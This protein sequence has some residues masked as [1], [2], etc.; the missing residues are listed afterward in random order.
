VCLCRQLACAANNVM[1]AV[2]C[3]SVVAGWLLD[4]H[5]RGCAASIC[6]FTTY[7]WHGQVCCCDVSTL[8]AQ[9]VWV[10]ARGIVDPAAHKYIKIAT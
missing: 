9:A 8:H 6:R 7:Y 5:C 2:A 3:T 4:I 1:S 10:Y